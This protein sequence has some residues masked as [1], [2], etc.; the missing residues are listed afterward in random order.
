[1]ADQE[2]PLERRLVTLEEWLM[3]TDRIISDL[4]SVV[5]AQ[6]KR[7]DEQ[8]RQ[9]KRLQQMLDQL[10]DAEPEQRSFEDERPPHY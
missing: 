4:N 8:A 1:M 3:H 6:H 9:I 5:C 10:R 2:S 7:I